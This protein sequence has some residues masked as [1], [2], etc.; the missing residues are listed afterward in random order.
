MAVYGQNR[1]M[2]PEPRFHFLFPAQLRVDLPHSIRDLPNKREND[3]VSETP[4]G[5]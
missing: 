2:V 4:E 5:N 1:I 3:E